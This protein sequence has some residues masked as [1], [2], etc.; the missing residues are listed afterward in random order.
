MDPEPPAGAAG[1]LADELLQE[2][3]QVSPEL[4]ARIL[5]QIDQ[6]MAQG[7]RPAAARAQAG[8]PRKKSNQ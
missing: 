1:T 4:R 5:R 3:V 8:K 7:R 2:E 6:A